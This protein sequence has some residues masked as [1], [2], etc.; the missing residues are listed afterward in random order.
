MS[1]YLWVLFTFPSF[2]FW[3]VLLDG[4]PSPGTWFRD[5][6]KNFIS[7]L[8]F[9]FTSVVLAVCLY[10]VFSEFNPSAWRAKR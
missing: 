5:R 2:I 7:A 4:V 9:L 3:F 10:H 1:P 6:G 8:P